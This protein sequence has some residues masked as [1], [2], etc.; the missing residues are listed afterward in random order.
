VKQRVRA[1]AKRGA[2]PILAALDR[3][4]GDLAVR[5]ERH[6]SALAAEHSRRLDQIDD[7]VRLDLRVVDEHLLAIAK[8]TGSNDSSPSTLLAPV[9]DS[10]VLIA[11]PGVLLEPIP[12]GMR[13]V[14]VSAFM[15]D[16]HGTWRVVPGDERTDTMRVAQLAPNP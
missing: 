9:G 1:A 16:E 3:R 14:E 4:L 12:A 15:A 13:I 11:P 5:L 7:R 2:A 10:L 8:A 6:T